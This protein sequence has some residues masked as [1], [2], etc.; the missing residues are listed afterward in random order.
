[1]V[2]RPDPFSRVKYHACRCARWKM[3]KKTITVRQPNAYRPERRQDEVA[4]ADFGRQEES[5]SY[6]KA[7]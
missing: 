1:M 6:K 7:C 3:K 4:V 2:V 5:E